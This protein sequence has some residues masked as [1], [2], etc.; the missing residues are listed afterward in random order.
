M[1]AL[2]VYAVYK[3]YLCAQRDEVCV[4]AWRDWSESTFY[5]WCMFHMCWGVH[6]VKFPGWGGVHLVNSLF[7]LTRI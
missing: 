7:Y 2:V 3:F 6:M 5:L 1:C 4:S